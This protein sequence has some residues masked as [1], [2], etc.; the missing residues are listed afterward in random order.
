MLAADGIFFGKSSISKIKSISAIMKSFGSMSRAHERQKSRK[1][2]PRLHARASEEQGSGHAGGESGENILVS[3]LQSV[4]CNAVKT[5]TR[6]QHG[7]PQAN[8][9]TG[10]ELS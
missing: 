3:E 5:R 6:K 8:Y 2:C 9:T 1:H 10:P 7:C 4:R